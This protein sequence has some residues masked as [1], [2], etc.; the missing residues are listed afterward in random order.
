MFRHTFFNSSYHTTVDRK[1]LRHC[2]NVFRTC[3]ARYGRIVRSPS[4]RLRLRYRNSSQHTD[5]MNTPPLISLHRRSGHTQPGSTPHPWGIDAM[6][7]SRA[8]QRHEHVRVD[9]WNGPV[10]RRLVDTEQGRGYPLQLYNIEHSLFHGS[11]RRILA[12]HALTPKRGSERV[13]SD[14][15]VT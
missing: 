13:F 8:P 9:P 5:V 15:E 7:R 6:V 10:L 11:L 1:S 14:L 3:A 2:R 4:Q 12:I